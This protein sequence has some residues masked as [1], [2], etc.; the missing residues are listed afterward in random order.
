MALHE[1]V[2]KGKLKHRGGNSGGMTKA[3]ELLQQATRSPASLRFGEMVRLAEAF[4]FREARQQ[5]SHHIFVRPDVKELVNTST[6]MGS[7]LAF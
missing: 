4:G 3:T 5:G 2:S 6:S 7:D 1:A